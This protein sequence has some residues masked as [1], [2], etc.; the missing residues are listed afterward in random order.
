MRRGESMGVCCD[1]S[2]SWIVCLASLPGPWPRRPGPSGLT[3]VE[4]AARLGG[5]RRPASRT[6]RSYASIIWANTFNLPN[7]VLGVLG[8]VTLAVGE[9]A[10]ALFLGI[11]VLNAVLGSVQ[12]IRA[13]HALER[14][15]A[16]DPAFRPCGAIRGGARG[17]RG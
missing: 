16:L 5:R 8:L 9:A 4:A 7:V 15:S 3:E 10:D 13:K 6:G 11:V 14:L 1:R 17:R 2:S 12:E